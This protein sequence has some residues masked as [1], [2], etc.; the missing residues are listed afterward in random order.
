M[1][2]PD[3][4]RDRSCHCRSR[5]ERIGAAGLINTAE[6]TGLSDLMSESVVLVVSGID[7]LQE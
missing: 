7:D 6:K 2:I 4:I 1:G 5:L 3:V